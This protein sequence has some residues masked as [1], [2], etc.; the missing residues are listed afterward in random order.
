MKTK[1][2]KT[3]ALEA[4]KDRRTRTLCDFRGIARRFMRQCKDLRIGAGA[5]SPSYIGK[6]NFLQCVC[7]APYEFALDIQRLGAYDL[8][9]MRRKRRVVILGSTGS[10]GTS[11]LKVARCLPEFMQVVGVAAHSRVKD[12][13]AQAHEFGVRH[14]GVFDESRRSELSQLL[15]SGTQVHVGAEGLC[16][17][18]ALTEADMILVAISGTAGLQP[19]LRA[20]E[21]GKDLAI[22]SKEVLVMAGELVMTRAAAA[23]IQVLPIDSEHN[24]I[25]QCI[26]ANAGDP[27][28]VKRLILTASG[29]PFRCTPEN[30]L[31]RVT[32][33]QALRHPT[34][35]MGRKITIDSATLFNKGLE[36][37]EARWLFGVP[38][39]KVDVLVHPQSI[40]HS[41]VEFVDGSML[42][43]LSCSDMC[44]PIQYAVT[45]PD[46]V[47]GKLRPLRLEELCDLHFELPRRD[48]F[49]ALDLARRAA[50]VGGTMPAMYN[51]ANEE[52]VQ[53]FIDGKLSFPGIWR[54]VEQVLAG[55]QPHADC[56]SLQTVLDDDAA[57]RELA[58][59]VIG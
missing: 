18:A 33:E 32:L 11:A 48:V 12:L 36:M 53:A 35:N 57:A 44:F 14:V 46:R 56:P 8:W 34:W 59:S 15:P 10:I 27:E 7:P 1:S 19:T 2:D 45:Y 30:E 31:E 37:I 38:I 22:A 43:Q 42:A 21:N 58:R 17:L 41:L 4:R 26:H 3:M 25:F 24:A 49:P 50:S 39:E 23:G 5:A 51:A 6:R 20:I 13:A 28:R 9:R 16:E 40:V 47:D 55:V 54:T 52:A 29:G